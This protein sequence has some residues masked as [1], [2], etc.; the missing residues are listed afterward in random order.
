MTAPGRLSPW[1]A[2][3]H[4]RA[5]EVLTFTGMH[6]SQEPISEARHD[7]CLFALHGPGDEGKGLICSGSAVIMAGRWGCGGRVEAFELTDECS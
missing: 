5:Q 3:V 1:P 2:A 7:V 4:M 6:A